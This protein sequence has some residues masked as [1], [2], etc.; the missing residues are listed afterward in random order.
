MKVGSNLKKL[1]KI[2][3]NQKISQTGRLNQSSFECQPTS[4]PS[5]R[6]A[7]ELLSSALLHIQSLDKWT[8]VV[9]GHGDLIWD[10]TTQLKSFKA[11][12]SYVQGYCSVHLRLRLSLRE[13]SLS[14]RS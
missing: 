7:N 3:S 4:L 5:S 2:I 12:K 11:M 9:C 14:P 6:Y 8:Y 1:E 10:V 13:L